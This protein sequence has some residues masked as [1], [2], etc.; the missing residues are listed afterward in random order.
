MS[1]AFV[2]RVETMARLR[3]AARE[4][5]NG[6][7][8][9]IIV[10]ADSGMGKTAL[11]TAFARTAQQEPLLGATN[12][13]VVQLSC[14]AATSTTAFHLAY[15][16][17]LALGETVKPQRTF[18]S[19]L[20]SMG[21]AAAWSTPKAVGDLVPGLG[22][23]VTIGQDVVSA[24]LDSGSMPADSLQPQQ[25]AVTLGIA[26]ELL[27]LVRDGAP[28]LLIL[29]DIQHIDL[30]SLQVLHRLVAELPGAPLGLV[31]SR[32]LREPATNAEAVAELLALWATRDG[33]ED[34]SHIVREPLAALP[35]DAVVDWVTL[36]RPEASASEQRE[37]AGALTEVTAG[38]PVF[39]RQ[40]LALLP[41]DDA[42]VV[43][44]PRRLPEAIARRF[45]RVE[46]SDQELLKL[47]T[48]YG[49]TFVAAVLAEVLR[50]DH[51]R[52]MERLLRISRVHGLIRLVEERPDWVAH[53]GSDSYEFE[54]QALRA[55]IYREHHSDGL[56]E[57]RH[58]KLADAL[59]RLAE[60]NW[61]DG[62][63]PHEVRL[64]TARQLRRAGF[65]RRL[66]SAA[67]HHELARSVALAGLSFTEAEQHCLVAIEAV[68]ALEP[69]PEGRRDGQF[70]EAVE[71]LL[72]LTE[73]RWQ[74]HA[75]VTDGPDI[76]R[77]AEEA[78]Q[79][80]LRLGDR[81]QI[82]RTTL[83]RGKT[84]LVKYGLDPSLDK[85]AA[86]VER[87]EEAGDPVALF[88][89]KV[90]YGR[91]LPKRDLEA[92]LRVL[93]EAEELYASE[94]LLGEANSPVLQHARN[95]NE[96]QLGVNLFDHGRF[97]EGRNRLLRCTERL[98][99]E[100]L[101]TELPIALNYLAQ[102]HLATG[103]FTEAEAVLTEAREIEAARGADSGWHAY[104]TAL[105]ALLCAQ[106]PARGQEA[107]E[108]AAS[109]WA[110]TERTWL[111]NLVPIVRNLY[112][113]VQLALVG[114]G[115]SGEE[116]LDFADRLAQDTIEETVRSGMH[117]SRIAAL[118]LRGRVALRR[119][120]AGTAA[121]RA[122]EALVLLERYGDMPAL[123][124]EEV[125]YDAACALEAVG[126]QSEAAD[127]LERARGEVARK[128]ASIE[129]PE[130]RQRFLHEV[131]LNRWITGTQP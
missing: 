42:S 127:L 33:A 68:R 126:E 26:Q 88:V 79:A 47:A 108:L 3:Q 118:S 10:E 102:L 6:T 69:D 83:L 43:S 53:L 67:A 24:A 29:D 60:R 63:V 56:S 2:D 37:L 58:A 82:A 113:E 46:E 23:A 77:L 122:R 78:E 15:D 7:G 9:L 34:L 59:T 31:V 96:M 50:E 114:E 112:V 99:A 30:S 125:L 81:R 66:D 40:C 103:E 128:A 36:D 110:E 97:G 49:N 105:L 76:D 84:L 124:S 12:C 21:V 106:D 17:L 129:E 55:A 54:H 28:V 95:L 94:P 1:T 104:N 101:S 5:V 13:R 25:Q 11:L 57:T 44:L 71:L 19:K 100:R 8:Q 70:V 45:D 109:A 107:R 87:A 4:V 72:S 111:A 120:D 98:R 91:Q 38:N 48:C 73:V 64:A 90:E 27:R 85:L 62:Q 74:G 123:R 51:S 39:L 93:I 86:S 130:R 131:P 16:A 22:A 115:R 61:Q 65:A 92:G 116:D 32:T 52:V 41:G 119:G 121:V 20:R 14:G 18:W 117:R 35:P 80:A 75:T 89:A